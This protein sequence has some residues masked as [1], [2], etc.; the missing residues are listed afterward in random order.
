MHKGFAMDAG[1]I[2]VDLHNADRSAVKA[3]P[4]VSQVDAQRTVTMGIRRG[5]L[6]YKYI[7]LGKPIHQNIGH[8]AE[9]ARGHINK[10]L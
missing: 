4:L 2:G 7:Y 3:C 1:H 6:P 5:H 10:A 8:L 9:T